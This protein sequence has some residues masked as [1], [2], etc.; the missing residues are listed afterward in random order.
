MNSTDNITDFRNTSQG[1]IAKINGVWYSVNGT[2][3]DIVDVR[4]A[5]QAAELEKHGVS[6]D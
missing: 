3:E 2:R 4:Y 5:L 6:N 1:P